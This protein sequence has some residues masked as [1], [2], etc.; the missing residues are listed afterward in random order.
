MPESYGNR[1]LSNS[2]L[3]FKQF[4]ENRKAENDLAEVNKKLKILSAESKTVHS[5]ENLAILMYAE[6]RKNQK[7]S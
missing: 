5:F 2:A 4:R 3:Y 7:T 6:I 1:R